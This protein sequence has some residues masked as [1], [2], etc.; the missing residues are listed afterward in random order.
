MIRKQVYS[1]FSRKVD[2]TTLAMSNT[3]IQYKILDRKIQNFQIENTGNIK[4]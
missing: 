1:D 2:E 3:E 4:I